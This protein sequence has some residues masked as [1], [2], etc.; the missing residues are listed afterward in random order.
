MDPVVDNG[1]CAFAAIKKHIVRLNKGIITGQIPEKLY[2]EE[3]IGEEPWELYLN[4]ATIDSDKGKKIARA[5]QK[6]VRLCPELMDKLCDILKSE[7][8]TEDIANDL[9]GT[10]CMSNVVVNSSI[11]ISANCFIHS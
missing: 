11:S 7:R 10:A 8:A 9:Q 4:S 2:S 3:L 6:N 5:V 1:V